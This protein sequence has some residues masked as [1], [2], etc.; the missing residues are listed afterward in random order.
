LKTIFVNTE[1]NCITGLFI[2]WNFTNACQFFRYDQRHSTTCLLDP[3]WTDQGMLC[4][5]GTI[6]SKTLDP[7][8]PS[9]WT[10]CMWKLLPQQEGRPT[11][12]LGLPC[13]NLS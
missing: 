12:G 2:V 10:G 9:V 1:K 6:R 11:E 3:G 8:L 13:Q 5:W 7:P 4:V